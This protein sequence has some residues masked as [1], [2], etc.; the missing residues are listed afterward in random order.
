MKTIQE[1]TDALYRSISFREGETPDYDLLRSLFTDHARMINN[2]IP[3]APLVTTVE[4]FIDILRS[5][6][7]SGHITAFREHEIASV[8]ET[9]GTIAHSFSTYE[10]RF[11]WSAATPHSVGINS[12]QF[13]HDGSKW[14]VCSMIWNNATPERVIPERYAAR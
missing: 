2:D 8:V 11:D 4:E 10:A 14:R 3:A 7:A 5:T 12:I 6:I 13:L 9:F 1:T